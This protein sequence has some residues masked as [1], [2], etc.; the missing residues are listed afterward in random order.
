MR[1]IIIVGLSVIAALA[2]GTQTNL[3]R[4]ADRELLGGAL[5][6]AGVLAIID[7]GSSRGDPVRKSDVPERSGAGTEYDRDLYDHWTDSDGDCMNTRHELLEELSTGNMT[8]SDNGCYVKT[9][10][11]NDPYTGNVY[12]VSRNMD[13]DH[14]VP[15]A[16]AHYRGGHSWDAETRRRFANDRVNLFAVQASANRS[17]GADGPLDWMPPD[18]GF[19]CQYVTRF[20]RIVRMYDL[21]YLRGEKEKMDALRARVCG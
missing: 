7:T 17:K 6:S 14:M 11:W 3:V 12:T 8:Y 21:E 20:E 16:W 15:L 4:T 1:N 5:R 13:V 9:G 2:A 19:H 18:E 10:R